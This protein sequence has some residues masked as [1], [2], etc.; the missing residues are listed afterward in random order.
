VLLYHL[1][2]FCW[3][4]TKDFEEVLNDELFVAVI[5]DFPYDF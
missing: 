3:L 4:V 1:Q 5:D 2:R